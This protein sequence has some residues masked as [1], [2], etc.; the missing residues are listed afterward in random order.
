MTKYTIYTCT[1]RTYTDDDIGPDNKVCN[2]TWN[3]AF[4]VQ[5]TLGF[6]RTL[7]H[8]LPCGCTRTD[9]CKLVA[10]ITM[11]DSGQFTLDSGHSLKTLHRVQLFHGA[12]RICDT[13]GKPLTIPA[14]TNW[15]QRY[16][17]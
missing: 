5:G 8:E 6:G 7:T 14:L 10:S 1:N 4:V 11:D 12:R 2:T 3:L 16:K 15:L 13:N 9:K 17:N